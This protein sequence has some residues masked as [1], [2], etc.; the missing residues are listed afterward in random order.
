MKRNGHEQ[1]SIRSQY[2]A[3]CTLRRGSSAD[4]KPSGFVVRQIRSQQEPPA[5]AASLCS[6]GRRESGE[7][8]R[9]PISTVPPRFLLHH[10]GRRAALLVHI[11]LDHL[12][13]QPRRQLAVLA[14]LEKHADDD[15]RIAPRRESHKPTILRKLVAGSSTLGPQSPAKRSAPNQFCRQYRSRECA[16]KEPCP[17]GSSTRAIASVMK[18][19]PFGSIGTVFTSV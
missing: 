14:A 18:F 4:I 15:I 17:R 8:H 1:F 19:H 6:S 9:P 5:F 12:G 10:L 13:R 2:R 16:P 7:V 3:S 11:G